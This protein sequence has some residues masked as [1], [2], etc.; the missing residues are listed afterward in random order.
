[1]DEFDVPCDDQYLV[2]DQEGCFIV[3]KTTTIQRPGV[4]WSFARADGRIVYER[5]PPPLLIHASISSVLERPSEQR[6]FQGGAP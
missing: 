2:P 3:P 5:A 4:T 6:E 1:M